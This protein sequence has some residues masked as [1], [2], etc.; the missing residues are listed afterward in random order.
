V[1]RRANELRADPIYPGARPPRPSP[2]AG[3]I[4]SSAGAATPWRRTSARCGHV[5][6][7]STNRHRVVTGAPRLRRTRD[8]VPAPARTVGGGLIV[9][10]A[11]T[12]LRFA[13][14]DAMN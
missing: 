6:A 14:P 4:G 8:F 7:D 1:D 9:S 2:S 11:E 3:I 12:P 13:G 10:E 5:D